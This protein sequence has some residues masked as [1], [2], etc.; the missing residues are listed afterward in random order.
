M[1]KRKDE[2]LFCSSRSCYSRIVRLVAPQY[3]EVACYKHVEDL[4]KHSDKVL[5]YKNGVLRNHISSTGRMKRGEMMEC[6]L[7]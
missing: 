4:E 5:G 2:C 1:K 7:K 3:D 6:L